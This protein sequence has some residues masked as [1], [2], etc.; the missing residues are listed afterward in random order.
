MRLTRDKT[1]P[2][3]DHHRS[4]DAPGQSG[5]WNRLTKLAEGIAVPADPSARVVAIHAFE[6]A[7]WDLIAAQTF[8]GALTH[9]RFPD[10]VVAAI[11]VNL[12]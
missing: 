6:R 3:S 9:C 11:S 7:G 1:R 4:T 2:V 5:V 10:S 12:L 8:N